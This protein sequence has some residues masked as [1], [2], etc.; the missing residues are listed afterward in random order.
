MYWQGFSAGELR[1]NSLWHSSGNFYGQ[2]IWSVGNTTTH[3]PARH[4]VRLSVQFWRISIWT[5]WIYSC[6][7]M[8]RNS[9]QA[10]DGTLTRNISTYWMCAGA[11]RR[12]SEG[13][14]ISTAQ[15][16]S[17]SYTGKHRQWGQNSRQ[18]LTVTLWMQVTGALCTSGMQMTSLSE[19]SGVKGKRKKWKRMW[20]V[21]L[22]RNSIWICRRKRRLSPTEVILHIS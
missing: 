3:T 4:R 5:S 15:M 16:K 12:N 22:S 8:R 6:L 10:T 7:N 9:T 18:C 2:G 1:M 13:T 19:L 20:G 11:K 21:L 17:P 14:L